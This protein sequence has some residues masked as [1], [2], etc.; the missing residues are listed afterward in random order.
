METPPSK[1]PQKDQQNVPLI[2]D[3]VLLSWTSSNRQEHQRTLL[4]YILAAIVAFMLIVYSV[5]T[6]SWSFTFLLFVSGGLYVI[7][8]RK[9]P[10]Q[11]AM[12]IKQLGFQFGEEFIPWSSIKGFWVLKHKD[13][14]ELHIERNAKFG[15]E[16]SVSIQ[17]MDSENIRGLL[18]QFTPE[19]TDKHEKLFDKIIRISKL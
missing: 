11:I 19:L 3:K 14:Q 8:H 15:I 12:S 18:A 6:K 13:F 16:I 2:E 1:E 9:K 10:K 4:W 17:N 5:A 7:L